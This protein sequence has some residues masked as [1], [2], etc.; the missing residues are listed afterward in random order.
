MA[1][2]QNL[3][4]TTPTSPARPEKTQQRAAVAPPVDVYENESE[5][6]VIADMPGVAQ[7][8]MTI[9]FE[10]GRLTIEGKRTPPA[11]AQRS[12]D[13]GTVDFRRTFLVPQSIDSEHISAELSQGVLQVHLPKHANARPRRIEVKAS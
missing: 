12:A 7:D 8:R 13:D 9:H 10:K 6:L 4:T 11:S 3:A 2:Q 5:V 1:T